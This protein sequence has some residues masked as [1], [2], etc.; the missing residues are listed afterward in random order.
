MGWLQEVNEL[1]PEALRPVPGLQY[2]L[3]ACWRS[4]CRSQSLETMR[5]SAQVSFLQHLQLPVEL[6]GHFTH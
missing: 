2:V 4:K 6:L 3:C 5:E 1:N